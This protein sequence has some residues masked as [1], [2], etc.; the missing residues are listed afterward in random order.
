MGVNRSGLHFLHIINSTFCEDGRSLVQ[1][2]ILGEALV[3]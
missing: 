1:K 3:Q 2:L